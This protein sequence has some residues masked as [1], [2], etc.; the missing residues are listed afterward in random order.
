M[1]SKRSLRISDDCN[2]SPAAA[3]EAWSVIVVDEKEVVRRVVTLIK[4]DDSI[5]APGLISATVQAGQAH[6]IDRTPGAL[7]LEVFGAPDDVEGVIRSFP[8]NGVI[9]LAR[10]G[11]IVMT[12]GAKPTSDTTLPRPA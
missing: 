7:I 1:S 10:P 6:L 12:R 9:E 3:E 4:L 5:V 8:S 2:R 11:E